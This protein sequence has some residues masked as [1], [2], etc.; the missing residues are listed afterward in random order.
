MTEFLWGFAAGCAAMVFS[1]ILKSLLWREVKLPE[2]KP[3]WTEETKITVEHDDES[4]TVT[5]EKKP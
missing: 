4:F 2:D 5:T 3:I 1:D